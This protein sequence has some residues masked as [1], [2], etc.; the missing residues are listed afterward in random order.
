MSRKR[1]GLRSWNFWT[2]IL[3]TVYGV[4]GL[5]NGRI[6]YIY[7][8]KTTQ[9]P[10]TKR[11][12]DELWGKYHRDGQRWWAHTVLGWRPD[13]NIAEVIAAGGVFVQW[14][15][16]TV[17]LVL[18]M[19]ETIW[20]IRIRRPI[21]NIQHNTGNRRRSTRRQVEDLKWEQQQIQAGV[22]VDM[23]RRR[24]R[25]GGLQVA[26]SIVALF[27]LL[28]FLPG[29]PAA[30]AVAALWEWLQANSAM[31]LGYAVLGLVGVGAVTRAV[32]PK[33]RRRRRRR[34]RLFR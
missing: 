17:P 3:G 4:R 22:P 5:H 27:G 8:G 16:R 25:N 33:R 10:W 9:V 12:E 30:V 32:R 6:R 20:A 19:V 1:R 14:Q 21:H 24:P 15:A 7:G 26:L 29:M 34:A 28:M 2:P 23:L 31:L 13:G 18:S 11:L